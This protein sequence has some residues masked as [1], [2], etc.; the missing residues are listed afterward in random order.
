MLFGAINADSPRD[1]SKKTGMKST[2]DL[3]IRW[4]P[5]FE[6]ETNVS[7]TKKHNNRAFAAHFGRKNPARGPNSLWY[8]MLICHNN[9]IY[10]QKCQGK[11]P[12][13]SLQ[14]PHLQPGTPLP[15]FKAWNR[16]KKQQKA[17]VHKVIFL[18]TEK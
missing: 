18:F 1:F 4:L 14:K 9:I 16:L 8:P 10:T 3:L 5:E 2:P 17:Q 7:G 11:T 12:S 13:G 6:A 15:S